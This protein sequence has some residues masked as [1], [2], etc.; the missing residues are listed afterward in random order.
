MSDSDSIP[1]YELEPDPIPDEPVRVWPFIILLLVMAA[2][3]AGWRLTQLPPPPTLVFRIDPA[4][5]DGPCGN[6]AICITGDGAKFG[7]GWTIQNLLIDTDA[8]VIKG[9]PPGKYE[10][11]R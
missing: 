8:K 9:L 11:V 5:G 6:S 7:R 3:V 1:D 4:P 10:V 2:C